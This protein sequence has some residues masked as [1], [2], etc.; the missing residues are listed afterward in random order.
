MQHG[1]AISLVFTYSME[2]LSD[3]FRAPWLEECVQK[4]RQEVAYQEHSVTLGVILETL[5]PKHNSTGTLMKWKWVNDDLLLI[6]F[7]GQK[8]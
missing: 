6:I 4:E 7:K 3:C 2:A 1:P 8:P 5:K